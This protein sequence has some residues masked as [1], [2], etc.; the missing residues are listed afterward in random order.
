M[1]N[2]PN[3]MENSQPIVNLREEPTSFTAFPCF[4]NY[5]YEGKVVF[6]LDTVLG[7]IKL[8]DKYNVRPLVDITFKFMSKHIVS[9]MQHGCLISWL[10]YAE[11][12][13][14][15]IA[16]KIISGHIAWNFSNASRQKDFAFL[17]PPSMISFLQ[18]SDLVI[19]NEFELF[20]C[21]SS[22]F[23]AYETRIK[24]EEGE[25]SRSQDEWE[26]YF[27]DIVL[28]VMKHIRFPMM[29]CR[30][31]A[32]MLLNPLVNRYKEYF[33]TRLGIGMSFHS[34]QLTRV[35]KVMEL[36][37]DGENLFTPRVYTD[38]KW[39][40][41][42]TI[43]RFPYVPHYYSHALV[44]HSLSTYSEDCMEAEEKQWE[45]TLTIHPKGVC[46]KK[47]F[48]IGWERMLEVPENVVKKVRFVLQRKAEQP[49]AR[50]RISLLIYAES[51]QGVQ[52][53]KDVHIRYATFDDA[54]SL[55]INLDDV[56]SY[57]DLN[58]PQS[59]HQPRKE[60]K[61]FRY[62]LGHTQ[63]LKLRV[64]VTPFVDK[65]LLMPKSR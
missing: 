59:S 60:E 62:L 44:F 30:H 11:A 39:S 14:N 58:M 65:L 41:L 6:K 19:A 25:K 33:V 47:F 37:P 15:K 1:L 53:V 9:A 12:I 23:H 18:R 54:D 29:S 34:A 7:I 13:G 4:M 22:W 2:G 45:W 49:V 48:M 20:D 3:W 38:E 21:V 61:S 42:L 31:L 63:D 27:S 46:F 35:R 52:F 50:V 8:A 43:E 16:S 28:N 36:E 17:D 57:E 26:A 51:F 10:Q 32:E 55:R 56:I 5:L 64:V 40:A 24:A